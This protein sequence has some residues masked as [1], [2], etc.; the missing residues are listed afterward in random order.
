MPRSAEGLLDGQSQRADV[1]T[2][3]ELH[4]KAACRKDRKRS[5]LNRTSCLPDDSTVDDLKCTGQTTRNTFPG[6]VREF[7]RNRE[8][9]SLSF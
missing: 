2:M 4:T 8:K 6:Q 7:V 1:P 3:P 9:L 5:L